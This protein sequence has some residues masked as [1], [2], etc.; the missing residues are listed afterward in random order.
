MATISNFLSA[1]PTGA[2][3]GGGSGGSGG[4][5]GINTYA[6]FHVYPPATAL[7]STLQVVS[8]SELRIT[9]QGGPSSHAGGEVWT[10]LDAA[11]DIIGVVRITAFSGRTFRVLAGGTNTAVITHFFNNFGVSND[12]DAFIAQGDVSDLSR[13]TD[14]W[15]I[16]TGLYTPSGGGTYLATGK[17]YV[18]TDNT[19]PQATPA[20]AANTRL[21]LANT[22]I[23]NGAVHSGYDPNARLLLTTGSRSS[24]NGPEGNITMFAWTH[25]ADDIDDW[26]VPPA[27]VSGAS[28][29]SQISRG[30]PNIPSGAGSSDRAFSFTYDIA[31]SRWLVFYARNNGTAAGTGAMIFQFTATIDTSSV[32]AFNNSF[33]VFTNW[34][35]LTNMVRFG[36]AGSS[37]VS[38]T[39]DGRTQKIETDP[40]SGEIYV[41]YEVEGGGNVVRSFNSDGTDGTIFATQANNS[42]AQAFTTANPVVAVNNNGTTEWWWQ[43]SGE[44]WMSTGFNTTGQ[45]R[46]SGG[47]VSGTAI[48]PV[49]IESIGNGEFIGYHPATLYISSEVSRRTLGDDT[50]RNVQSSTGAAGTITGLNGNLSQLVFL[51]IG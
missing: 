23:Q 42:P 31:N 13:Y 51:Q 4:G 49:A 10:V 40:N 16:G 47:I 25:D 26:S 50:P 12:N 8:A 39:T 38:R 34:T 44:W 36:A 28:P 1:T 21:A 32:T 17:V 15:D 18:D 19:Y 24:T 22:S 2:P 45:T 7:D 46:F 3:G 14:N 43:E 35:D 30:K 48:N 6:A 27:L 29:A 41:H 9:H 11:S 33:G 37:P 5:S 20:I